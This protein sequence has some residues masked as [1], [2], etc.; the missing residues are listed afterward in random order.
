MSAAVIEHLDVLAAD[1]SSTLVR[2]PPMAPAWR[3]AEAPRVNPL[4]AAG[5]TPVPA[6][7]WVIDLA[8]EPERIRLR[9]SHGARS[10]L[11]KAGAS[12]GKVRTATT[13]DL[14]ACHALHLETYRR[15][16][17]Q[18]VPIAAWRIIFERILPKGLARVLLYERGGRIVAAHTTGLYKR[19]AIYWN[20]ASADERSGG[21]NRLLFDAQIMAARAAGCAYF[22]AGDAF[23][24]AK[25]AKSRGL[26]QFKASFGGELWPLWQGERYNP[27]FL[28]RAL[29][30]VR[31]AR[32]IMLDR[33]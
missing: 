21:E 15:T 27:R 33:V 32:A 4:V 30:A 22:D 16:G 1:A 13:Q 11:K 28:P 12:G 8:A 3:H 26:S 31:E 6:Q 25:D 17:A 19:A 7:S 2:L 20:G 14:E 23:P 24:N 5:F 18:P 9:Y 10:D 29:R